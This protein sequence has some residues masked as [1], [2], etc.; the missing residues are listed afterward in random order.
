MQGRK[1]S[2]L[3][4]GSPAILS[5]VWLCTPGAAATGGLGSGGTGEG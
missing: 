4:V 5:K 3:A 1:G 2:D